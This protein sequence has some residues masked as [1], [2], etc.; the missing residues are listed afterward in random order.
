MIVPPQLR[1]S[2]LLRGLASDDAATRM[3]A[4]DLVRTGDVAEATASKLL[5]PRGDPEARVVF[6]NDV[7][8][9][10]SFLRGRAG[11]VTAAAAAASASVRR[12]AAS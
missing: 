4:V 10:A 7:R 11:L 8:S 5:G 2:L 1:L 9:L 12:V 6:G 3:L